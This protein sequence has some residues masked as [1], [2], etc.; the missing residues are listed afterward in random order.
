MTAFPQQLSVP[1]SYA[2]ERLLRRR[3]PQH[4]RSVGLRMPSPGGVTSY[5]PTAIQKMMLGLPEDIRTPN[6]EAPGT[7]RHRAGIDEAKTLPRHRRRGVA[8]IMSRDG[9]VRPPA[10]Q[11]RPAAG[12]NSAG[13]T[14]WAANRHGQR[15]GHQQSS[16]RDTVRG[17][18]PV[19]E[20]APTSTPP[21][22][23]TMKTIRQSAA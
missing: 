18:H 3:R 6:T 2:P 9:L 23:P 5:R 17:G 8:H 11:P 13:V 14:A 12:S 10:A 22:E 1:Q 7:S 15:A 20:D 16:R 19:G 21:A 4:G